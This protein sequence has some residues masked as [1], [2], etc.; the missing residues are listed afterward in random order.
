MAT[1]RCPCRGLGH[2]PVVLVTRFHFSM[3]AAILNL[4]P[5][6]LNGGTEQ[7]HRE[8]TLLFYCRMDAENKMAASSKKT[9]TRASI[10]LNRVYDH[11]E[12]HLSFVSFTK[13]I[14]FDVKPCERNSFTRDKNAR[15]GF[16]PIYRKKWRLFP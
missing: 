13:S 4:H 1:A 11:V 6:R 10:E 9:R 7:R 3:G 12:I 8:M 14:I 15:G 2:G 16:L 5:L